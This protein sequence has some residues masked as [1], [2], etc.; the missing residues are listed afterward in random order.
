MQVYLSTGPINVA[1]QPQWILPI[2]LYVLLCQVKFAGRPEVYLKY[3][4][5]CYFRKLLDFVQLS[6]VILN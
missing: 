3:D 4:Y 2:R 5:F 1:N 6:A